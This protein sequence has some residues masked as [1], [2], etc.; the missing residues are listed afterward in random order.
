MKKI[1]L[2]LILFMLIPRVFAIELT[3][4]NDYEIKYRFYKEKIDF[5]YYPKGKHLE[6]YLE[7]VNNI[8]YSE[9]TPWQEEC[10]IEDNIEIEYKK[11]YTYNEIKKVGSIKLSNFSS[12][13]DQTGIIVYEGNKKINQ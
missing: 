5:R 6:G 7:D 9:Y 10:E 12:E 3:E 8:K 2:S 13:R 11:E 1:I 4:L